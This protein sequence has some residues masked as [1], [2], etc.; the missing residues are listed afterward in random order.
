MPDITL[1]RLLALEISFSTFLDTVETD[2]VIVAVYGDVCMLLIA[3]LT[4]LNDILFAR[5]NAALTPLVIALLVGPMTGMTFATA[6]K[7]LKRF[8]NRFLFL[9]LC[10]ALAI[11]LFCKASILRVKSSII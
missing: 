5:E 6:L 8:F 11:S 10:L 3:E 9:T 2:L 4:L 1:C 7:T